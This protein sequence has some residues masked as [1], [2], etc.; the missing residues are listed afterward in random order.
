M[1]EITKKA[2]SE[3]L[4]KLMQTIPLT[5]ITVQDVV[6]ECGLNRR[7]LYYYFHDIYDLL[8]WTFK[9]EIER[10][11]GENRTYNTWKKGFTAL[12]EYLRDNK[13]VVLN[14]YNSIDRDLLESHLDEEVHNL[15][16]NVVDEVSK[17]INVSIKDKEY[18][19]KFYKIA[20]SNT[21]IDWVKNDMTEDPKE[22]V[23]NLSKILDGDIRR[24]L[25][26]YEKEE[27]SNN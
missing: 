6:E 16:F 19:T 26:R 24:T 10:I 5:K 7:T 25:L 11:L 22:V 1:S 21:I 9:S 12:L 17:D 14:T 20:L 18:V 13:R 4:K 3:S 27:E 8:K 15:I 2:L 23:D